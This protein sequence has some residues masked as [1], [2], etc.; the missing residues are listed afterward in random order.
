[1]KISKG[2]AL[3]L[4]LFLTV[5][6]NSLKQENTN[7]NTTPTIESNSNVES[8]NNS[9]EQQPDQR[10]GSFVSGEHETK[11]SVSLVSEEGQNFIELDSD[12]QT[13][14]LGPDLVVIL[15]READ[16][17][18]STNP[19]AYP[20]KEGDYVVIAPLSQYSGAQR[21]Q[22]P[23]NIN[24]ADYKSVGIWCRKFNATFGAAV[25]Q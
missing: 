25:L 17:I 19:P 8:N 24:L 15:H 22:I 6:C 14:E 21:Y 16:V 18:G 7:N 4:I 1:M 5:G 12:F 20:L 13:S 2:L 9:P 11:G 3:F 10:V 23:D